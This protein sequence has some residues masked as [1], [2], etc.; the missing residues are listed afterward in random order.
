M[1]FKDKTCQII[2]TTEMKKCI[3][4]NLTRQK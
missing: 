1:T 3:T 2:D 4:G